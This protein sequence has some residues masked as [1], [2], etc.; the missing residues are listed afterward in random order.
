MKIKRKIE[1]E[2]KIYYTMTEL[3]KRKV[4]PV[5]SYLKKCGWKEC[6][7]FSGEVHIDG[8]EYAGHSKYVK[9]FR[10]ED[11]MKNEMEDICMFI[12]LTE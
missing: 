12:S 7:G 1:E 9:Q 10:S 2:I 3:L 5:R 6:G 11:E 8:K 4:E